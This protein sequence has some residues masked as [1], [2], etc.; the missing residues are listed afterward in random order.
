MIDK[1]KEALKQ[2]PLFSE[3]KIEEKQ[4]LYADPMFA[5][6]QNVIREAEEED[7]DEKELEEEMRDQVG[8]LV[9][10]EA[11]PFKQE[12]KRKEDSKQGVGA[13]FK[14]RRKEIEEEKAKAKEDIK[15]RSETAHSS[16]LSAMAASAEMEK[17]EFRRFVLNPDV[18]KLKSEH[19]IRTR[20]RVIKHALK[21]D[22]VIT[23]R[24][25][26]VE[27]KKEKV[28]DKKENARAV[29]MNET[30]VKDS[31]IKIRQNVDIND[32]KGM[33]YQDL[34]EMS[35]FGMKMG[36]E[37][38]KELVRTYRD[39]ERL[40]KGKPTPGA[41]TK[42]QSTY[43]ALDIMTAEIMK[44]D[45]SQYDVHTDE[46]LVKQSG[47]LS[48]MARMVSA[49]Q[50]FLSKNPGYID[51]LSKQSDKNGPLADRMLTKI[52]RLSAI[53]QYYKLRKIV[54]EDP[55]YINHANEEIPMKEEAGDSVQVKRLKKMMLASAQA[56][57]NLQNIFGEVKVPDIKV[58]SGSNIDFIGNL[59]MGSI[60][61]LSKVK[62]EDKTQFIK[63][64]INGIGTANWQIRQ[65]ESESFFQAPFW[66][67]NALTLDPE[68]MKDM[69]PTKFTPLAL[70]LGSA[71][72]TF[73][74]EIMKE[75]GSKKKVRNE[76]FLKDYKVLR[77]EYG[78][79]GPRYEKRWKEAKGPVKPELEDYGW[80]VTNPKFIGAKDSAVGDMTIS[81]NWQRLHNSIT[82][83][84]AYKRTNAEMAE[85]IK[86]I[87]I[88]EDK[89]LW[90][91]AKD[92]EEA[93]AFCESAYKEALRKFLFAQYAAARRVNETVCMK[94]LAMHPTD[95]LYQAT[96]ELHAAIV[97]SATISNA[98]VPKQKETIKKLFA[99]DKDGNFAFDSDEAYIHAD[100]SAP[101][102]FKI[103][104]FFKDL[105]VTVL[106]ANPATRELTRKLY[107]NAHLYEDVIK[108]EYLAAKNA[109]D[110]LALRIS[111]NNGT[112]VVWWYFTK[113]PDMLD[114]KYLN[115][116]VGGK[117][118]LQH[119]FNEATQ[120]MFH[121]GEGSF[122]EGMKKGIV[123]IPSN[124]ELDKYQEHLVK[125]G[126]PKT[127][128][129]KNVRIDEHESDEVI[130][131]E[132]DPEE[133][134]KLPGCKE[135]HLTGADILKNRREDPYNLNLIRDKFGEFTYTDDRGQERI[136][137]SG[138]NY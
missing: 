30:I 39:G 8:E 3:Q 13:M 64:A 22:E 41:S 94:L 123:D 115:K 99:E 27:N 72:E 16:L 119:A 113:H 84:Y 14:A 33:E 9:K 25:T 10:K 28:R 97:L 70:H 74:P 36:D 45:E 50:S 1:N 102:N 4:N 34:E 61:D 109:N 44:L 68:A 66:L 103:T 100:M 12:M 20:T 52:T 35:V 85:M 124:E 129:E 37:A 67:Q 75:L 2:Q 83:V 120:T 118:V 5:Q 125:E 106:G 57:N 131:E 92:D 88:Q 49:Y 112:D 38:F 18:D 26:E 59:K 107:G 71:V 51:H 133:I 48:V 53:G 31:M 65:L 19:R 132:L 111:E 46:A 98:F 136:R 127:R 91:K 108:P 135:K 89:E 104:N 137:V 79:L 60:P 21:Q 42:E 73:I 78:T 62:E 47:E 110:P 86:N 134:I 32:K 63:A 122:R 11:K 121:G 95:L 7:E 82:G 81:D 6:P 93:R 69:K 96:P 58:K 23:E 105:C 77:K 76:E 90:E 17:D 43:A 117:Y 114:K 54:L 130:E 24:I 29:S 126:Y 56:A 55:Y 101:Q 80:A 15:K 138:D 40:K 87:R 128:T 116:K